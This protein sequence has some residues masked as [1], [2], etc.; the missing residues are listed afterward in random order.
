MTEFVVDSSIFSDSLLQLPGD[1]HQFYQIQNVYCR[2]DLLLGFFEPG[3][4]ESVLKEQPYVQVSLHIP[5][6]QIRSD[7]QSQS[8]YSSSRGAAAEVPPCLSV[9]PLSMSIV[10]ILGTLCLISR[11]RHWNKLQPALRT[12]FHVIRCWIICANCSNSKE[13][14]PFAYPSKLQL[15]R[16]IARFQLQTRKLSLS[17]A[18]LKQPGNESL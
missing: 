5:P 3:G 17:A 4:S 14:G 15:S 6:S 1:E 10:L 11:R 2:I 8:H 9:H 18:S 13:K 7:T 16:P 12:F